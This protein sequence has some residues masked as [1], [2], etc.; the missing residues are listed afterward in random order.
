MRC[1]DL[2]LQPCIAQVFFANFSSS[3]AAAIS[4]SK[5]P[6]PDP[7][8]TRP[9]DNNWRQVD[10]QSVFEAIKDISRPRS[11]SKGVNKVFRPY[12]VGTHALL[13]LVLHDYRC[14]DQ[15][16]PFQITAV[17]RTIMSDSSLV[18]DDE[19]EILGGISFKGRIIEIHKCASEIRALMSIVNAPCKLS[20]TGGM[21]GLMN[22]PR[23]HSR[24]SKSFGRCCWSLSYNHTK[25]GCSARTLAVYC[26]APGYLSKSQAKE[27]FLLKDD[28]IN[29]LPMTGRVTTSF[30][31]CYP[32]HIRDC[33]AAALARLGSFKSES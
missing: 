30:G 27:I 1:P 26:V 19:T 5:E 17:F 12:Y 7:S 31:W 4:A 24:N 32:K 25:T 10:M 6:L 20:Q 2:D 13:L 16:I 21:R 28:E 8:S 23:Y 29:Q 11:V 15:H 14:T 18:F 33:A 3:L 22:M 9:F